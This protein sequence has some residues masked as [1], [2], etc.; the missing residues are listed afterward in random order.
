MGAGASYY[1]FKHFS[2]L[3]KMVVIFIIWIIAASVM[4]SE[5]EKV[6]ELDLKQEKINSIINIARRVNKI[7]SPFIKI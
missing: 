1:V 7:L 2:G 6:K 5:S 4:H 3:S